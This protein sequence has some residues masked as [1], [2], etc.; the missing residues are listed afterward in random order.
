VAGSEP[1]RPV[2][3]EVGRYQL[4]TGRDIVKTL[5]PRAFA[6]VEDWFETGLAGLGAHP[7]RVEDFREKDRYVLRAE[8]PGVDP[9]HDVKVNVDRGVLTVE[10]ERSGEK[11]DKHRTEFRYGALRR[12]VTLPSGADEEKIS[13]RYD[14]GI[15]EVIVPLRRP[16][17]AGRSISVEHAT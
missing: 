4:V 12:S 1:I 8:L 16:G 13:A 11:H 14:K 7:I 5:V 10:A 2:R 6:D 15:L 9:E 17:P 3:L